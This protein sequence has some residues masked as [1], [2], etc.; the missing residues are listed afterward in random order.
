MLHRTVRWV[1]ATAAKTNARRLRE[2]DTLAYTDAPLSKDI[3][4]T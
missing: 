2:S 4:A 3:Q 1:I